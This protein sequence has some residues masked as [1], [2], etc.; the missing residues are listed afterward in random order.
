MVVSNRNLLLQGSI[1]RGYVSFRE[2]SHVAH[3]WRANYMDPHA[4]AAHNYPFN[5]S[6]IPRCMH[7][8]HSLNL[9]IFVPKPMQTTKHQKH[10]WIHVGHCQ[11]I[12]KTHVFFP[13]MFLRKKCPSLQQNR[14][15]RVLFY[16]YL[17]PP[18]DL[19]SSLTCLSVLDQCI[20]FPQ[21][22]NGS[23]EPMTP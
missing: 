3:E 4:F 17:I 11:T 23:L 22:K 2:G 14:A 8:R 13:M 12:R 19:S 6:N 15:S 5:G 1:F 16:N 10:G 20:Y 9:Y 21:K 7:V 18:T